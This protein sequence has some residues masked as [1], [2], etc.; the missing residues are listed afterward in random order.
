MARALAALPPE[1]LVSEEIPIFDHASVM[2]H[3]KK[4]DQQ[5][6]KASQAVPFNRGNGFNKAI[7]ELNFMSWLKSLAHIV[8]EYKDADASY[9]ALLS[10]MSF[11][12]NVKLLAPVQAGHTTVS[13]NLQKKG[14]IDLSELTLY[15]MDY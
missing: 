3:E 9:F 11:V 13:K 12:S 7:P 1:V 8:S 2:L 10:A 6:R 4:L 5:L 15:D 14:H